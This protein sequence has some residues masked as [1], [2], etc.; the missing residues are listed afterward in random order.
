[1]NKTNKKHLFYKREVIL[2]VSSFTMLHALRG[3]AGYVELFIGSIEI[4]E[5]RFFMKP[6]PC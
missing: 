5:P 2:I 1:M 3:M 6:L 4:D